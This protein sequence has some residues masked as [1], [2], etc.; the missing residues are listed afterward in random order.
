MLTNNYIKDT[1]H[2]LIGFSMRDIAK[3]A[4]SHSTFCHG[5]SE[6]AKLLP[7]AM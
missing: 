6:I 1:I 7:V 4:V 5:L 3:Q 2:T